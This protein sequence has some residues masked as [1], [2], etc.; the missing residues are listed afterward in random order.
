MA[1]E[2]DKAVDLVRQLLADDST[3]EKLSGVMENLI[4]S[5]E[6]SDDSFE[7]NSEEISINSFLSGKKNDS[8]TA[9]P[10][11]SFLLSSGLLKNSFSNKNDKRV[12]LLRALKP[13]L[14]EKRSS[15]VESAIT[16]M[17]IISMSSSMGLD[18]LFK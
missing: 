2:L 3:K 8:D 13:Y 12:T 17:Q 15:R 1:D 16:M 4:S 11:L 9:G 5:S 18:K 6:N 10:D 7:N 14:S